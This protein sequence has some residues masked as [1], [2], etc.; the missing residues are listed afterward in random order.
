MNSNWNVL[1]PYIFTATDYVILVFILSALFGMYNGIEISHPIYALLFANLC[2]AA[3]ST[4]FNIVSFVFVEIELY[5]RISNASNGWYL[6]FHCFAWCGTSILR[7]IYI[8][9]SEWIDLKFPEQRKLSFIAILGVILSYLV[10]FAPVIAI[11]I[12]L[13]E[14]I[15]T[16]NLF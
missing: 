2:A 6:V 10:C 4:L 1:V 8:L 7:Y 9:H 13:G 3:A 12:N 5:V 14:K 15:R 16:L 11:L